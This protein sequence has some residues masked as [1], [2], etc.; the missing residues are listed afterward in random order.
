MSE[1]GDMVFRRNRHD[2]LA[3]IDETTPNRFAITVAEME[4]IADAL[5]ALEKLSDEATLRNLDVARTRRRAG[6]TSGR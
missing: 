2:P 4:G 5:A 3:V 6:L 1:T